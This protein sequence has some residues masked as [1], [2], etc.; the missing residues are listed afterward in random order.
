MSTALAPVDTAWRAGRLDARRGPSRVLFGRMYEDPTIERA[1]FRPGNRVFCIASAGCT[2]LALCDEHDVVACDINPTQL[3]YAARRIGG[4]PPEVGAAERIMSVARALM[5]LAGWGAPRVDEFLSLDDP[6]AQ[7]EFFREWLDTWLFR[8]GLDALMSAAALR[9]V[10]SSSL[11]DALPPRFGAV[12]RAR[13]ERGFARHPNRT[14][15]YA[16]M[17]L[18]GAPDEEPPPPARAST[19]EL[20]AGDAA[21]YLESC[22]PR[23]FDGFTLSNILDGAEAAYRARLDSA[24]RRAARPGAVV[25]LRSFAEPAADLQ[26]NLAARDRSLLWGVVIV[27]DAATRWTR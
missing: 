18:A 24:V 3:A 16:Q 25:V 27:R 17:L 26:A 22:P 23:S 19:I 5:P 13:M 14:N 20:V 1:A 12:L 2:A 9:A 10:Y 15:P 21:S 7:A 11:V 8:I 4:G 6:A